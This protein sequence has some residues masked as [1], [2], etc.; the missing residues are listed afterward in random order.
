[1]ADLRLGAVPLPHY[2][3]SGCLWMFTM[4]SPYVT[5]PNM[6]DEEVATKALENDAQESLVPGDTKAQEGP[7]MGVGPEPEFLEFPPLTRYPRNT[8]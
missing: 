5:Q 7:S 6:A 1:M 8:A 2:V 4:Y 3:T